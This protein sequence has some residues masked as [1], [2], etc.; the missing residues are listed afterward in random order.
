M[1][2][3]RKLKSSG[4]ELNG[5]VLRS[6]PRWTAEEDERLR[7]LANEGRSAAV[8]SERTKRSVDAVLARANKLGIAIRRA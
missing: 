2:R 4:G 7:R 3:A 8:I 5:L 1:N 6:A